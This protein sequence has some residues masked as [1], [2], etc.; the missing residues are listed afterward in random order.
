MKRF[1]DIVLAALALLVL[2]IRLLFLIRPV[3]RKLS[4]PVFFRQT[5][6][7]LLVGCE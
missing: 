7:G 4:G 3:R 1:F 6:P 2:G 5:R